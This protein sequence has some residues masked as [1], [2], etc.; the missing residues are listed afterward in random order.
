VVKV[1]VRYTAVTG[2]FFLRF[3]CPALLNPVLF[4]LVSEQ[5]SS[6]V[7]RDLMLIAKTIQSLGR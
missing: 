4:G 6:S 7:Q 5:P 2:F 3:V 1:P